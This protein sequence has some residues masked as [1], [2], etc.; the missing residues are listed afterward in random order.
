MVT[1][2]CIQLRSFHGL[3]RRIPGL[4][5][6]QSGSRPGWNSNYSSPGRA[7]WVSGPGRRTH[8][9]LPAR[10]GAS[11][12]FE[13]MY[14]AH[15][16]CSTATGAARWWNQLKDL[17][18]L[19]LQYSSIAAVGEGPQVLPSE[20]PEMEFSHRVAI[21]YPSINPAWSAVRHSLRCQ[22]HIGTSAT[23]VA[24]SLFAVE[25]NLEKSGEISTSTHSF[26]VFIR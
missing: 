10:F 19:R 9:R 22:L 25:G 4:S 18:G 7:W 5:S 13:N 26:R 15:A 20:S 1:G 6:C 23:T 21:V 16:G 24:S 11:A 14:T 2:T 8:Y 12:P 3:V 17:L